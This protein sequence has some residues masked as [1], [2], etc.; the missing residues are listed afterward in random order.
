MYPRLSIRGPI[1]ACMGHPRRDVRQSHRPRADCVPWEVE[2]YQPP[3][4]EA[5][6]RPSRVFWGGWGLK[7]ANLRSFPTRRHLNESQ[8]AMFAADL[9][10]MG[11]GGDRRS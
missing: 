7:D 4:T 9:A 11:H 2:S 3:S 6:Y 10:D 1:E 8:R 5:V